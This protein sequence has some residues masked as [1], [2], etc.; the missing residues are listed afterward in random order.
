LL[1]N[2]TEELCPELFLLFADED[3]DE[4]EDEEEE[5]EEEGELP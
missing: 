3:E 4:D 5:K 2:S 1:Q